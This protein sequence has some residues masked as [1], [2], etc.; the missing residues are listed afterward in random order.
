MNIWH[1]FPESILM[2]KGILQLPYLGIVFYIYVF[3]LMI[4]DPSNRTF[5]IAFLLLSALASMVMI[6]NFRSSLGNII[7]PLLLLVVI[8]MPL[9]K[10][11]SS[12]YKRS[13]QDSGKWLL[14]TLAACIHSISWMVWFF[15]IASS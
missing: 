1:A 10:L 14:V 7:P 11:L 5:L 3:Y 12:L 2:I 6:I 13:F 4:K 15:V 8:S 9:L